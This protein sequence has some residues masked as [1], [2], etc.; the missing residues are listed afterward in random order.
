[1]ALRWWTV[2][3]P[4][5]VR[6]AAAA[7]STRPATALTVS[8]AW[9]SGLSEADKAAAMP[10]CAQADEQAAPRATGA[11]TSAF[12]GAAARAADRPARPAPMITGPGWMWI[13]LAILGLLTYEI[14]STSTWWRALTMS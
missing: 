9:A 4:S 7:S 8:T 2:L 10:P 3:G 6:L 14:I 12:A 11:R 1:M 5:A 13:G